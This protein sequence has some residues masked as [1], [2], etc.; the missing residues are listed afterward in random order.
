M[1]KVGKRKTLNACKIPYYNELETGTGKSHIQLVARKEKVGHLRHIFSI[2]GS[3]RD[4]NHITFLTLHLVDCINRNRAA[5]FLVGFFVSFQEPAYVSRLSA[6]RS[7]YC[8]IL[9]F[10][11][12]TEET[13]NRVGNEPSLLIRRLLT[14]MVD[15]LQH[16]RHREIGKRIIGL[17][18]ETYIATLLVHFM[19]R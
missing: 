11:A 9:L 19:G 17:I 10:D 6:E 5:L 15:V 3:Q 8:H 4:K 12:T 13:G 16:H 18:F 7:Q 14:L 2:A 1:R